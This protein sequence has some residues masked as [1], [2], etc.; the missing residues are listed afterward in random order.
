MQVGISGAGLEVGG[1]RVAADHYLI[2]SPSGRRYTN[3]LT[4]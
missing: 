2:S 1:C 3:N 4:P